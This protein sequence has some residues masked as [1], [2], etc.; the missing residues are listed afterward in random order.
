MSI[1]PDEGGKLITVGL[2]N[3][4]PS[5][6]VG[7]AVMRC[8]LAVAFLIGV[9]IAMASLGSAEGQEPWSSS[10]TDAQAE[11]TVPPTE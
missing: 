3:T 4:P 1:T 5:S 2:A 6:A 11:S 10:P 9:M 7:R 8:I